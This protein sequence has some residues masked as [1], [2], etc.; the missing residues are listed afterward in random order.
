MNYQT[1]QNELIHYSKNE[2]NTDIVLLLSPISIAYYT[3]F[4]SDPHERF[5]ALVVDVN[6]KKAT[7]FLPTLD[8]SAA[9]EKAQVD[10]LV[11][12]S[13]TENPYEKFAQTVGSPIQSIGLEKRYIT[14]W[15]YEQFIACI[16]K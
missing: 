1:R 4:H 10:K 6:S 14:V 3:G 12:V 5:F 15:Q 7:L 9:K 2:L 8:E 11:P 13:D 16:H